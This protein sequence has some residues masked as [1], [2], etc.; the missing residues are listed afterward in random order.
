MWQNTNVVD[1]LE[2]FNDSGTNV[3]W[4]TFDFCLSYWLHFSNLHFVE[5][6]YFFLFFS[7]EYRLYK[8][9][10]H[11]IFTPFDFW[12]GKGRTPSRCQ[13]KNNTVKEYQFSS[14]ILKSMYDKEEWYFYQKPCIKRWFKFTE[15]S[16]DS[17]K[18]LLVL[19]LDIWLEWYYKWV[20]FYFFF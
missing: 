19:E 6:F 18:I 3:F 4:V 1:W 13:P 16:N 17:Y 11:W 7:W 15:L 20:Y 12:K 14:E 8:Y 2:C 10:T 9:P 5:N